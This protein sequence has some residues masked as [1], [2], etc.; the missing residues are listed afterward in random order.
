MLDYNLGTKWV[1]LS[2]Q[3]TNTDVHLVKCTFLNSNAARI[4]FD[5]SDLVNTWDANRK[6]DDD[7]FSWSMAWVAVNWT[8]N[9]TDATVAEFNIGSP[10]VVYPKNANT[11]WEWSWNLT[12][13]GTI[14]GSTPAWIYSGS[15]DL[16]LQATQP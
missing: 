7:N 4:Q 10:H 14:P 12:I 5:M 13:R 1:S 8:L 16:T 6:I 9:S 11:V 15:L 3:L 2:D